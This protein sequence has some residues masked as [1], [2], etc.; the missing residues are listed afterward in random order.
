M[1]KRVFAIR[2][3][4]DSDFDDLLVV[5]GEP[6]PF[7]KMDT[8]S[9]YGK[10]VMFRPLLSFYD[11]NGEEEKPDF[12]GIWIEDDR[13]VPEEEITET[14]VPGK[15]RKTYVNNVEDYTLTLV[16]YEDRLQVSVVFETMSVVDRSY[17]THTLYTNYKDRK[18]LGSII[19]MMNNCYTGDEAE[20]FVKFL[21][22]L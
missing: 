2:A 12:Q 21:E 7:I 8:D 3:D 17:E 22:S 14:S 13:I 10:K 6:H 4:E 20:A 19:T 16:E 18:H 11:A 15:H 5:C 9:L 1:K